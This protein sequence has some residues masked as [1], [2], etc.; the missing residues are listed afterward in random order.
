MAHTKAQGAVRGN[1]DSR[2]KRLGVKLYQGHKVKP[3]NII[4]RQRGTKFFPGAGV[5]IGKD[6][7]IFALD[8]GMVSFKILKGK[9][10]IEV[11]K[12]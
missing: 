5:D 4:V 9:K 12:I 3:G 8:S 7:S 2:A 1:R 6:H 10:F 11:L